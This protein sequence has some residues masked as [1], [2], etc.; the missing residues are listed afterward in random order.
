[1]RGSVGGG[2]GGVGLGWLVQRLGGRFAIPCGVFRGCW[3]GQDW[4][5]D[6][7]FRGFMVLHISAL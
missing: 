1:M 2:G 3:C 7:G 5:V 4:V 6:V